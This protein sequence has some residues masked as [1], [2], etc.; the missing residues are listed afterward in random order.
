MK[1][2]IIL[3]PVFAVM[4]ASCD[5]LAQKTNA[6]KSMKYSKDSLQAVQERTVAELDEY[7]SII[8]DVDSGFEEIRRNENYISMNKYT[9]GMPSN[10]VKQRMA[11]NMY[12]INNILADNK[13]KIAELEEKLKNSG[14]QS[15]S[16]KKS[17]ANLKSQME[18][19]DAEISKLQKELELK[20]IKIDSLVVENQLL[21][22]QARRMAEEMEQQNQTIQDQEEAMNRA[23]YLVANRKT[24]RDNEIDA[25]N[26]SSAFRTS[27]FTPIDIREVQYIETNSTRAKVLTKHPETSYALEKNEDR[28][29]VLVIK[30]ATDFWSTS[31]YL[32]IKVD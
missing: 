32:I 16:L 2:L 6:Y 26:M 17:I 23:Y 29:C 3:I 11:D 19:K 30:N 22:E 28:K 24:L 10:E 27:L 15:S 21:E 25:R 12:T 1:K 14:V 8:Q 5:Q 20:N 31:K 18:Q 13:A 9:D 7:L 4:L